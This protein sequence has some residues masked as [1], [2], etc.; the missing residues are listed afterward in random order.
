[1]HGNIWE[2]CWDAYDPLYY[3][4]SPD[5]DPLGKEWETQ[6]RVVRGG[7]WNDLA[8]DVC[9]ASRHAFLPQFEFTFVG[10]RIARDAST[11]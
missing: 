5:V 8:T 10:F 1:M 3:R 2:W 7:S 6:R 9:A 4:Q 11:P